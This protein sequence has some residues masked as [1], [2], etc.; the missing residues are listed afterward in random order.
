MSEK[1]LPPSIPSQMY[2][3]WGINLAVL[4]YLLRGRS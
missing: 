4:V 3:W 1:E 2:R